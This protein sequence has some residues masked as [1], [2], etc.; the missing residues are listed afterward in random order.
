MNNIAIL[1]NNEYEV[2]LNNLF[3]N[4]AINTIKLFKLK[5]HPL[6]NLKE[7]LNFNSKIINYIPIDILIK[8][9]DWIL[10]NITDFNN[11]NIFKEDIQM[12]IFQNSKNTLDYNTIKN[13]IKNS[14]NPIGLFKANSNLFP[15]NYIFKLPYISDKQT[16]S[17]Y[18]K[19]K[20]NKLSLKNINKHS[21]IELMLILGNDHFFNYLK[22]NLDN[23]TED[24]IYHFHTMIDINFLLSYN[25]FK[26][27]TYFDFLFKSIKNKDYLKLFL[28]N[29]NICPYIIL[30]FSNNNIAQYYLSH[31]VHLS[32][33]TIAHISQRK[34]LNHL[35]WI[36]IYK[37]QSNKIN[38]E[39][40]LSIINTLNDINSK[41][42]IISTFLE[43]NNLHINKLKTLSKEKL[44]ADII[45][46]E[47]S[48]RFKSII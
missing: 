6:F 34:K 14:S 3:E 37:H 10:S 43:N 31:N 22:T 32:I 28:N 38:E 24:A 15:L 18:K 33:S 12:L 21:S 20:S 36:H 5:Q 13:I 8:Y 46:K 17:L 7:L 40:I 23:F 25:K 19:I 4:K 1:T 39:N 9:K 44:L 11:I 2:I 35:N 47:V 26:P 29:T 48:N 30:L 27:R 41:K 45:K 16:K 42:D